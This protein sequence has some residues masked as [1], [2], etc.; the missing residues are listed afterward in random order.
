VDSQRR[1]RGYQPRTY[2]TWEPWEQLAGIDPETASANYRRIGN[3]VIMQAKQNS[4]VGN[5]SFAVKKPYLKA[6]AFQLTS[7]V[8]A[9]DDWG[10]VEVNDRQKKLA[11]LAI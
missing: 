2:T 5:G 3:M 9:Y 7:D 6:S 1:R 11:K 8:Y 10:V 4:M